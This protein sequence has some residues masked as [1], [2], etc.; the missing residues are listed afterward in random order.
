MKLQHIGQM[1]AIQHQFL[2]AFQLLLDCD[3][4]SFTADAFAEYT[5]TL[6]CL[7]ALSGWNET[8]FMST[9][10][11]Q[12]EIGYV[13]MIWCKLQELRERSKSW[14]QALP[15]RIP[16]HIIDISD[17][18]TVD[19]LLVMK[20]FK[21]D[22]IV[23]NKGTMT[24]DHPKWLIKNSTLQ[25]MEWS[26]F[27]RLHSFAKE[28]P[29]IHALLITRTAVAASLV[30]YMR[31]LFFA[32]SDLSELI[33]NDKLQSVADQLKNY[34]TFYLQNSDFN[35]KEMA[36]MKDVL[37]GSNS[38]LGD[39]ASLYFTNANYF[40][41]PPP[42]SAVMNCL[43]RAIKEPILEAIESL[44]PGPTLYQ[45]SMQLNGK[46]RELVLVCM[47]R[48]YLF[49]TSGTLM[50]IFDY[51][52]HWHEWLTS[53]AHARI[54]RGGVLRKS[55][56]MEETSIT[57]IMMA[58]GNGKWRLRWCSCIY[59][60]EDP[61]SC[62]AAW[63]I[64]VTD[65]QH[66]RTDRYS[67]VPS[68]PFNNAKT[69]VGPTAFRLFD[70]TFKSN[71]HVPLATT[72]PPE[73]TD[74]KINFRDT[75]MEAP[76]LP[77][78]NVFK[79]NQ[80]GDADHAPDVGVIGLDGMLPEENPELEDEDENGF[81][82]V[83]IAPPGASAENSRSHTSNSES[84]DSSADKNK[85]IISN[86]NRSNGSNI[87]NSNNN[88]SNSHSSSDN[89]SSSSSSSSGDSSRSS[90]RINN[91]NKA[92]YPAGQLSTSQQSQQPTVTIVKELRTQIP[93]QAP[94][95]VSENEERQETRSSR[96]Y[97][98]FDM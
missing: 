79:G 77:M 9:K 80:T 62:L 98:K 69:T 90:N 8:E 88:N 19:T 30:R 42:K 18:E 44:R 86:N 57:P 60:F 4:S 33:P 75:V 59:R 70:T 27:R 95:D 87:H 72:L 78:P 67:S 92:G 43:S 10:T 47:I 14:K 29:Q 63:W 38:Y 89:I 94:K 85:D 2:D 41:R 50:D 71:I 35:P 54:F 7:L 28:Q 83:S 26:T 93:W 34:A 11:T 3:V 31:I 61:F 58:A 46:M 1:D 23:F 49:R 45:T 81:P 22:G 91:N 53:K 66:S 32:E 64:I 82:V 36:L 16:E 6:E 21:D 37:Y 51:T 68:I 13:G 48:F 39:Y 56:F 5:S 12:D 25:I 96:R 17:Q 65:M 40:N 74:K 20:E 84:I 24:F 73:S 76:T 52:I 97:R 55:S 15:E